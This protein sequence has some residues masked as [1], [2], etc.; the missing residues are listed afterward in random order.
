MQLE[1]LFGN[2][3]IGEEKKRTAYDLKQVSL[4][5]ARIVYIHADY[6]HEEEDAYNSRPQPQGRRGLSPMIGR[7]Y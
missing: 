5:G 3:T 6:R 4:R 7:P 2:Q 1:S